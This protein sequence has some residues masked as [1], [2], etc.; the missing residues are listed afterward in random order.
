VVWKKSTNIGCAVAACSP[1]YGMKWGWLMVC[2]YG[3]GGNYAG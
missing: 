2:N 3:P 1:L